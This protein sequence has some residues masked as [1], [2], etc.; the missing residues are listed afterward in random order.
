[1]K[2]LIT[3][4]SAALLFALSLFIALPARAQDAQQA[5]RLSVGF[6][7]AK[8]SVPM[9]EEKRKQVEDLEAK[10]RAASGAQKY[11]EAIKHYSHG[12]ALM[13]DQ[14]WT[15][16][17]AMTTAL[18]MKLERVVFD[19]GDTARIALSQI[20]TLDEPITGKLTGSI[21][22]KDAKQEVAKEL[23]TLSDVEPDFTK[24]FA[25]EAAIPDLAD[26]D[27]QL[28]LM[29]KLKEGEPVVKPAA[30][31]IARGLTAQAN[32]LKTRVASVKADLRKR[33][34]ES[35]LSAMPAVEH[36]AAMLDQVNTRQLAVENA[37]LRM[38]MNNAFSAL[39]R[40]TRQETLL[41]AMPAV[42][43]AASMIDLVNAG[44]LP[45]ERTDL[46]TAMTSAPTLLDQIEKGAHPL[47]LTRGD[48]N[49]AY[50]SVVDDTLQ[51]YRF[52]VP[53][54]YDAKKKWPLVVALHGMGGDENSFFA[55]YDNGVIRTIAEA[56]GYIVAC[57]KGRQPAS[58]YVGA[59]ERDVIDVIKEMKREFSIDDNRVY[60]MGHSMG[61]Y[62]SWSVAVNNPDLFA[63]IGPIAGGG[64][65][66]TVAKLKAISNIPWIVVHGDKD[67][68]VPVDESRKMVKAGQAL[69]IKIK[70]IEVPGGNHGNIVVP[71]F[72]DIFDWFDAHKRQP[73]GATKAAATTGNQ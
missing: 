16:S 43:Y 10:A 22:L 4:F 57:P 12:M 56:R 25:I 53:T 32:T 72:T 11:G 8:N 63:A 73:K 7:T 21:A 17:R 38:A 5:L 46:K 48:V 65:P 35:M 69:G 23:K 51:P 15:P 64:A 30:V 6:R 39:D 47:R 1:M 20:F 33:N 37:D 29:L 26:G 62:G 61:G 28:V 55:G 59:A 9:S 58:M 70:Y 71:A 24:P 52:Y 14:P 2:N 19:P 50:R 44:Q 45:V 3:R 49:W 13:R 41:L 42:E 31:R 66:V 36:A 34:Q 67:P 68:T 27:Y 18:Q 40:I 60:L 54:N